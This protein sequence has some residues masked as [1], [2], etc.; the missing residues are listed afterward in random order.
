M[1]KIFLLLIIFITNT[2][3]EEIILTKQPR[4]IRKDYTWEAHRALK[5]QRDINP[6]YQ[7]SL[8]FAKAKKNQQKLEETEVEKE[9]EKEEVEIKK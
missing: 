5:K 2:Y 3:S 1:K 7:V 6:F 4:C 9:V 8:Q